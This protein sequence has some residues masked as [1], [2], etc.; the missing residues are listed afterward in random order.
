MGVKRSASNSRPKREVYPLVKE[1][2]KASAL[3]LIALAF[4]CVYFVKTSSFLTGPSP[5]APSSPVE[6]SPHILSS[7]GARLVMGEPIDV[8]SATASELELLP[9]IG[10]VLAK[11]IVEARKK[12]SGFSTI[13]ELEQ[14]KGLSP[15]RVKALAKYIEAKG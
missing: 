6:S 1:R 5:Q 10:P 12:T 15:A 4:F 7:A 9:G 2:P 13:T 11:R 8:N 14:V 3:L